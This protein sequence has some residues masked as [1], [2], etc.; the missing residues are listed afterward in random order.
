[1]ACFV[2][3]YSMRLFIATVLLREGVRGLL[4][5]CSKPNHRADN[6]ETCSTL[7]PPAA[8]GCRAATLQAHTENHVPRLDQHRLHKQTRRSRI[9]P[10]VS[11]LTSTGFTSKQ[12]VACSHLPPQ[13]GP[14]AT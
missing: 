3:T 4:C 14:A 5:S 11:D 1:M 6:K 12:T 13:T 10:K 9:T 8:T 2:S 7:L